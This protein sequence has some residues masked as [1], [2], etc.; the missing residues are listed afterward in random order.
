MTAID[1]NDI[2]RTRGA[3]GL[4]SLWDS[5]PTPG[6]VE[7]T[8]PG[9]IDLPFASAAAKPNGSRTPAKPVVDWRAHVSTAAALQAKE[10]PA[11]SYVVPGLIPEGLTLL[12]GK[13]KIGKSW[14]GLDLCLA[15]AAGRFCLGDRR[16][17]E[18]DVLYCALED[19][20]RRLQ[21][22]IDKLLGPSFTETWPARLTLTTYWQRL[23]QGGVDDIADWL[24]SVPAGRFVVV[25][26]LAAVRPVKASQG[27]TEDYEALARC[28]ASRTTAASRSW[29]CITPG[30][31]K[32]K[33]RST[34]SAVRSGWRGAPT[35]SS[36]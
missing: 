29:C 4:R 28:I 30:R 7:T 8:L 35:R 13:P 36:S 25:D 15:I 21:R 5:A 31:W 24:D 33:T 27:Y 11:V 16:P 12:A 2:A 34:R 18:G 20:P 26:T 9:A 6:E 23:D 1:A 3:E 32:P 14:L 10:F 17:I 22:R 19:N